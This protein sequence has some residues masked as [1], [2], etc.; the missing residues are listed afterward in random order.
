MYAFAQPAYLRTYEL[1][2][3][4]EVQGADLTPDGGLIAVVIVDSVNMLILLDAAG[5]VVWG[6]SYTAT[7]INLSGTFDG[8]AFSA[9]FMDVV[10]TGNDLVVAGHGQGASWGFTGPER[11][12]ILLDAQGTPQAAKTS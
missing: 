8:S 7:G 11:C 10:A 4:A 6:R 3:D 5:H 9:R 2:G 12:L 1:P